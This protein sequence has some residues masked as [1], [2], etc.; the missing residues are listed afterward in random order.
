V[1]SLNCCTYA[2]GWRIH[3]GQAEGVAF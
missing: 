1:I 3:P 2:E